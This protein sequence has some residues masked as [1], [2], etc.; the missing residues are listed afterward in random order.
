[1]SGTL[2]ILDRC[3]DFVLSSI[4]MAVAPIPVSIL[5][6]PGCPRVL[7]TVT[8]VVV[9]KIQSP[10]MDFAVIPVM[11]IPVMPIVDSHLNGGACGP[12]HSHN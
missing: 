11:V 9:R 3:D 12:G 7:V 1:M 4:R 10:G 8:P 6:S 5:L 2:F